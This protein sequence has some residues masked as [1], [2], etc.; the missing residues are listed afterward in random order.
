M[1]GLIE[2]EQFNDTDPT[3]TLPISPHPLLMLLL[4][5]L[6]CIPSRFKLRKRIAM[7]STVVYIMFS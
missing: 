6:H 4:L 3:P 5:L 7:K 1:D 2:V